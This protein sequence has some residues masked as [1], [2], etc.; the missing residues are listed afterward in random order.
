[1]VSDNSKVLNDDETVVNYRT[2]PNDCRDL[3]EEIAE[4][5][6]SLVA[7]HALVFLR[8]GEDESKLNMNAPDVVTGMGTPQTY[9]FKA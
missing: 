8:P 1:M 6:Q 9:V 4:Q 7:R 3:I 5:S 2:N